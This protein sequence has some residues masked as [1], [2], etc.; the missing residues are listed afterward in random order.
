MVRHVS[1]FIELP[2]VLPWASERGG[3]AFRLHRYEPVF[4]KAACCA[5][6]WGE[7]PPLAT[8]HLRLLPQT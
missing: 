3:E 2:T 6:L 8:S 5:H 4:N 7:K 1:V